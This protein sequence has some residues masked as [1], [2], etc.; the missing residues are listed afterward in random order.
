MISVLTALITY[1]YAFIYFKQLSTLRFFFVQ[2][3]APVWASSSLFFLSFLGS[4]FS[5]SSL[6]L[7]PK[8]EHTFFHNFDL[9]INYIVF[10]YTN[11]SYLCCNYSKLVNVNVFFCLN[12]NYLCTINLLWLY[13]V[14]RITFYKPNLSF[15][16]SM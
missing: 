9:F 16:Y 6:L 15:K 11:K 2:N 3:Q 1:T 13:I 12:E 7:S 8:I 14:I 10:F 4:K 5:H